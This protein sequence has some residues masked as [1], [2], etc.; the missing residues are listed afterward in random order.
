LQLRFNTDATLKRGQV[1]TLQLAMD[2]YHEPLLFS[3]QVLTC[4]TGMH[5]DRCTYTKAVLSDI[6]GEQL[7]AFL[8]P[9]SCL[10]TT[11][12]WEDLKRS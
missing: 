8:T 9:G 2:E 5:Q 7:T 11:Y 10:T 6:R 4:F 3:A 1:L 12:T